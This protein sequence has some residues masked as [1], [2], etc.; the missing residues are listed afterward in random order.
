MKQIITEIIGTEEK[1]IG[2][3]FGDMKNK[4]YDYQLRVED[5]E[6]TLHDLS[7]D[8]QNLYASNQKLIADGYY[9]TPYFPI[10][11]TNSGSPMLYINSIYSGGDATAKDYNPSSHN[12]VELVNL[13]ETEINL[14]GLYLHY[15]EKDTGT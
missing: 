2:I 13:I 11:T 15:T 14:N 8:K 3:N 10:P 7:L 1:I 4:N 12:F 6:I 5:G 9:E